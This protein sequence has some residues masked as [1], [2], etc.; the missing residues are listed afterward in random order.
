MSPERAVLFFVTFNTVV[1]LV[2]LTLTERSDRRARGQL[3]A[4]ARPTRIITYPG[5][6][7]DREAQ[8][9]KRAARVTLGGFDASWAGYTLGDLDAFCRS[10]GGLQLGDLPFEPRDRGDDARRTDTKP[11]RSA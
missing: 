1:V 8:A 6:L 3:A 5:D 7:T 4:P 10:G 11:G 2:L 9:L